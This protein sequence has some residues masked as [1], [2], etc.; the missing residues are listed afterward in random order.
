MIAKTKLKII[1]WLLFFAIGFTAGFATYAKFF[2]NGVTIKKVVNK[3]KGKNNSQDVDQT[4][5]VGKNKK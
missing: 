4:F 3:V 2:D 1:T 5:N